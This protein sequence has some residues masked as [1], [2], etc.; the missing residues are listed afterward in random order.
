MGPAAPVEVTEARFNAA[1]GS[2]GRLRVR[3]SVNPAGSTASLFAPGTVNGNVCSG[4]LITTLPTDPNDGEFKFDSGSGA[5]A[6][7]PG[8]VCVS[9]GNGSSAD[10]VVI[11]E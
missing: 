8:S 2:A 3:G 1:G 11:L 5:F 6:S 10:L 4:T 9:S 7:D